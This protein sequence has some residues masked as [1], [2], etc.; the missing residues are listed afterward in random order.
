MAF[1]SAEA[2]LS[3][4]PRLSNLGY[5]PYVWSETHIYPG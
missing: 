1:K 2:A 4:S 5:T 3:S